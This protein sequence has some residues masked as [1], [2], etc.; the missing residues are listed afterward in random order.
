VTTIAWRLTHIAVG[1]F[2]TRT[3]A[4]FGDGSVPD[5]A[6]MFDPWH[7]PADLPASAAEAITFLETTYQQWHGAIAPVDE[8]AL[9][10][11]LGPKGR[12]SPTTRWP[13]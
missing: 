9:S 3:S 7:A 13:S 12:S 8:D 6:T 11:P 10:R 2:A 4:F 5:D 1:C